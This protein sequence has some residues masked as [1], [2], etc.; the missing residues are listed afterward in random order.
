MDTSRASSV[1]HEVGGLSLTDKKAFSEDEDIFDDLKA[2]TKPRRGRKGKVN[3]NKLNTAVLRLSKQNSLEDSSAN[4]IPNAT[5]T[6]SNSSTPPLPSPSSATSSGIVSETT[7]NSSSR[8]VRTA[9]ATANAISEAQSEIKSGLKMNKS[10]SSGMTGSSSGSSG[11]IPA[12]R[13][14]KNAQIAARISGLDLL[15]DTTM[16]NIDD[17]NKDVSAPTGCVNERLNKDHPRQ[18][19]HEELT[20]SLVAGE[21]GK[22]I[23]FQLQVYLDKVKKQYLSF[24]RHIQDPVYKEKIKADIEVEKKK[25]A[26]LQKREK[27]LKA[28]IDNLISD[29][30]NLL[31]TRLSELGIQ[32]KTPPEFIEKAKGIVCQHHELQRNK[33]AMENEVRQLELEQEK[34]IQAKEKEMLDHLLKQGLSMSEARRRIKITIENTIN[35]LQGSDNKVSPLLNKL[36]DVTLTRCEQLP[37]STQIRKRPVVTKQRD[38]P[39]KKII[40]DEMPPAASAVANWSP[41]MAKIEERNPEMLAKKIIAQG[42]SL[43]SK[44]KILSPRSSKDSQAPVVCAPTSSSA[45][46]PSAPP[47]SAPLP[48]VEVRRI[49]SNNKHDYP[50]L[51][52]S[53]TL[54]NVQSQRDNGGNEPLVL[55]A[56]PRSRSSD[57]TEDIPTYHTNKMSSAPRAP[58]FEDRLKTIIHS[59]LS[60]EDK[61]RQAQLQQQQQQKPMFSPI[62]K[63]LPTHLPPP[64]SGINFDKFKRSMA[65]TSSSPSSVSVSLPQMGSARTMNEIIEKEMERNLEQQRRVGPVPPGPP[66]PISSPLSP[67]K[68]VRT[69]TSSAALTMSRMSQVIEDSIRGHPGPRPSELEGLACPR[70]KSPPPQ[71]PPPS[72]PNK[73]PPGPPPAGYRLNGGGNGGEDFHEYPAMEGL[74]ARFGSYLAKRTSTESESFAGKPH[75]HGGG[76]WGDQHPHPNSSYRYPAAGHYQ[77]QQQY[78]SMPPRKRASPSSSMPVLPPKKQHVDSGVDYSFPKGTIFSL[79]N[80]PFFFTRFF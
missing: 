59:V 23:P 25:K 63:E 18:L 34:M 60:G 13:K 51:D 35:D 78:N 79:K 21:D 40:K 9:A 74:G 66:G 45:P 75:H 2:T 46:M 64:P 62:K 30:L 15:H 17:S 3:K 1:E 55:P 26:E 71:V 53:S 42:R 27:Q 70:T 4:E 7:S 72:Q 48:A 56:H 37:S 14:K 73:L 68:L 19:V 47:P 39:E 29:S 61:E 44:S 54:N 67:Q 65:A 5:T 28:Q 6:D 49:E 10:A 24:M 11:M 77:Q 12:G 16:S 36:A 52:L 43:E 41:E 22:P 38:W 32:A 80:R 58:Q 33:A 69:P 8:P 31:K 20:T 50:R 57:Q 76:S